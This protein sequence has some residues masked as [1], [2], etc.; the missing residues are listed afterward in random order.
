MQY[1]TTFGIVLVLIAG[2]W[3]MRNWALYGELTGTAMM[4][5]IFGAR[6][7]SL[8]AMQL[9][10]QLREVWETFWVGFGW[11]NIRAQPAVY[12]VLEIV[13]AMSGI[14]LLLGFV[15]RRDRFHP[16]LVKALPF[17]VLAFWVVVALVELVNWMQ[18]TQAPHG[19]LF[20]PALPALAPLAAFGLTQW[21]PKRVEPLFARSAAVALFAFASYTPFAILQPA[22]AYPPFL[23]AVPT[24]PNHVEINYGDKMK[25]LGYDIAPNRIHPG[26]WATLTLYW[27][28]IATM[29]QDYSIG[30]HVTDSGGRVISARDSYPGHGLLPT[31]LWRAGQILRDSYWLP[32]ADDAPAPGIAWIQ[33]S[34]YS[35]D[36]RR[37]LPA[38]DPNGNA[39]STPIVGRL[40]ISGQNTVVPRPQNTVL[41]SFGKSIEL[42]GY[43]LNLVK[44]AQASQGLDLTLY[45]KRA[46]PIEADYTVFVHL[47]DASGKVV[48]QRDTQPAQGDNPTSLWGDGEIVPDHYSF[49]YI[50]GADHIELGFY[51]TQT[52]ERLPVTDTKGNALGDRVTLS[53]GIGR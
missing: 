10:T 46:A 30:I 33:V 35:R 21:V 34:L 13:V 20:F 29:D 24:N 16:T 53:V 42:I 27:Q 39:V 4:V 15:R 6:E 50:V 22:Y 3:Y 52:G 14:G 28:S 36:N 23:S 45:W 41:Y 8:T 17:F 38:F 44:G 31:R 48:A 26:E 37:D 32:I 47:L 19:R 12:T 11:G 25:L 5:R 1:L 9:L 51:S 18:I 49:P 40:K 43:D 7:T 2:W